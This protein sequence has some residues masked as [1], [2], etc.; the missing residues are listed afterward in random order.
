MT[1]HYPKGHD[2]KLCLPFDT[3][4][5]PIPQSRTG[6]SWILPFS[7]GCTIELQ[8][9]SC[10]KKPLRSSIPATNMAQHECCAPQS[11]LEAKGHKLDYRSRS[12]G[13]PNSWGEATAPCPRTLAHFGSF[14]RDIP[15]HSSLPE[16]SKVDE[17]V[18]ES[19]FHQLLLLAPINLWDNEISSSSFNLAQAKFHVVPSTLGVV[20]QSWC[21]PSLQEPP[22]P[23]HSD[24]PF[25]H[26]PSQT[27]LG[28]RKA[29]LQLEV[30]GREQV[31]GKATKREAE[32]AVPVEKPQP[33][34]LELFH[35][36][37]NIQQGVPSPSSSPLENFGWCLPF[38]PHK[39]SL[40]GTHRER[41][42]EQSKNHKQMF[43][44]SI[45]PR[46]T[47]ALE[48]Q[49][50][51]KEFQK[52]KTKKPFPRGSSRGTRCSGSPVQTQIFPQELKQTGK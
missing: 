32:R 2:S 33:P 11:L 46:Q 44:C 17:S 45:S 36:P 3:K 22:S 50:V 51:S 26:H 7:Q 19:S 4:T 27:H 38:P 15:T 48:I 39:P 8:N 42:G 21:S 14:P 5:K 24:N 13:N 52:K 1:L 34:Q 16:R 49:I 28:S 23:S 12:S 29:P 37:L 25:P 30:M 40:A 43:W 35:L 31:R 41:E 47:V 18:L 9:Y 10:W 20:T 6:L